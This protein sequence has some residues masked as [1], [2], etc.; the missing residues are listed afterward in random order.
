MIPVNNSEE[1]HQIIQNNDAVFLYFSG[2][3]CSVCKAL[4]PKITALFKENF[5]KIKLIEIQTD[6]A[7]ETTA[8]FGVFSLPTMMLYIEQ[9]EFLKKGRNVSIPLLIEEIK[10]VYTLFLGE[11]N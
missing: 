5:P 3:N 10:R 6:V 7:I 11:E 4:K 1:V 8:Q 2:E 9:K